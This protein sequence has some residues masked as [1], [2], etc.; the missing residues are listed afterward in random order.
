LRRRI[1]LGSYRGLSDLYGDFLLKDNSHV[2]D[3][4]GGGILKDDDGQLGNV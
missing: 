1:L 4:T 3:F 2:Y